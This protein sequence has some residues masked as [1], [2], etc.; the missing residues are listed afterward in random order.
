MTHAQSG[1]LVRIHYVGTLEDGRTFDSSRGGAP[2]E[3]TL[4]EGEVIPGFENAVLGMT[5]GETKTVSLPPEDAYGPHR[6]EMVQEIERDLLPADVPLKPGLQLQ[7]Q[8]RD[9]AAMVL[10]VCDVADDV[11]TLDANHPL[12][13]KRLTFEI[14]LVELDEAA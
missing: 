4:G 13:G 2:L 10:V 14:E 3:F 5:P 12:A 9:G 7:A 1:H 11:V 8:T 6:P